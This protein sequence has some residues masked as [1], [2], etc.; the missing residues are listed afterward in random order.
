MHVGARN[1][2]I[3]PFPGYVDRRTGTRLTGRYVAAGGRR[4]P[5]NRDAVVRSAVR[6]ASWAD[7]A[8]E[9]HEPGE[10]IL[11]DA[12]SMACTNDNT[13]A[14]PLRKLPC[15]TVAFTLPPD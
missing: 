2:E 9:W 4:R 11:R 13:R 8:P 7:D 6:T 5:G 14:D 1:P 10:T 12:D 15:S 3:C